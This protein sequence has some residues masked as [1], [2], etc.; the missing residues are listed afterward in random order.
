M[1]IAALLGKALLGFASV[2]VTVTALDLLVGATDLDFQ[3]MRSR[4]NQDAVLER[5]E[6]LTRVVTNELGFREPRLPGRKPPGVRRI[7]ALGDSFTQG[8]GVEEDEAYPRQLERRLENVEVI[9]LGVPGACPLD[10]AAILEDVGLAYDPDLVL[11]GVM[12]N[13]VNDIRSL[14]ELDARILPAVLHQE[15]RRLGD[16][17][18]AWKRLPNRLWPNLYPLAGTVARRL[19]D[20]EASAYAAGSPPAAG[21][22]PPAGELPEER[23]RD[24]LL[25]LAA[26][27]DA[28]AE[29]EARLAALPPEKVDALRPV[30]TG[31]ARYDEAEQQRVMLELMALVQPNHFT[32]MLGM[33]PTHEDAWQEARS[34]LER[35]AEDA[36]EAGARTVVVHVPAGLQVTRRSID[37]LAR[38]GFALDDDLLTAAGLG[39]RLRGLE[40]EPGVTVVDLLPV[41][42]SRADEP[43]YYPID[44]H[45][46]PHGH[47]VAA[48]ALA[49]AVAPL[50]R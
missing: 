17:R 3:P 50:L 46:T 45:W 32:E 9:N 4:P 20:V 38:F 28:V 39:E 12:A 23:W 24:V 14:R 48:D 37:A 22:S 2:A 26:R 21:W 19:R 49:A 43:L 8:Y 47:R 40:E 27:Y 30:L 33:P 6:F 15:Q 36:R 11:V 35:I 16:D 25:R 42:R 18:P 29:V 1:Q 31:A 13:D 5:S 7:V 34:L 44:G 41:L 10:Y